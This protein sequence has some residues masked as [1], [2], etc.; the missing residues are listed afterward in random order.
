MIT[1]D[2]AICLRTTTKNA[3]EVKRTFG[4]N[5]SNDTLYIQMA[6][7]KD[8]QE[9]RVSYV[10]DIIE[11]R[12]SEMFILLEKEI[13]E[14]KL[15]GFMGAGLVLTGGGAMLTGIVNIAQEIL[16]VPVRVGYP[17]IISNYNEMADN[18]IYATGYGLILY[19]MQKQKKG[20]VDYLT[21]SL[22][23]RIFW[24]M[25]SWISEFF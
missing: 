16:K 7:G 19:I 9:V 6:D 24:R 21:E 22:R 2:I 13:A 8:I 20:N 17:N 12:V 4:Q 3:E 5:L 11:S 10:A 23:T 25:K 1:N 14:N 15:K 18:P